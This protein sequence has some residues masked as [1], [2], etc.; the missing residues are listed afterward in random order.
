MVTDL[1]DAM[2]DRLRAEGL[3]S[4]VEYDRAELV[5]DIESLCAVLYSRPLINPIFNRLLLEVL[6]VF[7]D[8]DRAIKTPDR[9]ELASTVLPYLSLRILRDAGRTRRSRLRLSRQL[10]RVIQA[11]QSTD[12]AFSDDFLA[13]NP[14]RLRGLLVKHFDLDQ[15]MASA[16]T[17]YIGGEIEL[18]YEQLG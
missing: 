14:D 10:L 3:I 15:A 17:A 6:H 12:E 11:F 7:L 8:L 5:R 2:F 16:L 13:E 18:I 4:R 1:V 9:I